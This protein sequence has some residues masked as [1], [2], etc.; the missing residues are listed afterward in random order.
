VISTHGELFNIAT[1]RGDTHRLTAT[2]AARDGQPRWSP[3]GK[4]I[5]YVS[6]QSGR[7]EVWACDERGESRKMLTNSDNLKGQLPWSPDSKHLLFVGSDK[8][9]YKY[10]FETNQTTAMASGDVINF[11]TSAVMNPQWSPDGKWISYTKADP[12]LLSH[13]YVVPADGGKEQRIT[14]PDT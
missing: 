12:T 1:D 5:A 10:S 3:D 11:G 14:D 13:V 8:K 4:W 7:E 2:P 9:L 6:D